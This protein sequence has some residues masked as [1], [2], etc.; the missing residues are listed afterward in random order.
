MPTEAPANAATEAPT[1]D[2]P[3]PAAVT[4][5]PTDAP[6]PEAPAETRNTLWILWV[7]LALLLCGGLYLAIRRKKKTE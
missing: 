5:A 7:I 1:K 6:D 4:A 3:A 2:D